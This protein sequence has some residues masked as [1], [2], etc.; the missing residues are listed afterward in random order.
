[1]TDWSIKFPR[2]LTEK[3]IININLIFNFKSTNNLNRIKIFRKQ[4]MNKIIVYWI[5]TKEMYSR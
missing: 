3:Q 4:Q 2:Y 5:N 1:M